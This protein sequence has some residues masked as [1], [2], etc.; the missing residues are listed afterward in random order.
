MLRCSSHFDKFSKCRIDLQFKRKRRRR[1]L[2]QIDSIKCLM[3]SLLS[4]LPGGKREKFHGVDFTE[5]LNHLKFLIASLH[6]DSNN[7]VIIE[8]TYFVIVRMIKIERRR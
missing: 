7:T 4:I 8:Y 3:S 5:L 2:T 6:I 1:W